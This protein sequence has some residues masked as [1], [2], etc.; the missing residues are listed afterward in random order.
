ML[1]MII[2]IQ[3]IFQSCVRKKYTVEMVAKPFL[4]EQSDKCLIDWFLEHHKN[5]TTKKRENIINDFKDM[6]QEF[7]DFV[8]YIIKAFS[9]IRLA[10]T[11]GTNILIMWKSTS[12]LGSL[13]I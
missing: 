12:V 8:C 2:I 5:S 13:E 10:T 9:L 1:S 3:I 11:Y 7:N 4:T 6:L